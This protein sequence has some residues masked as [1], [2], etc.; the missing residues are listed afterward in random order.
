MRRNAVVAG[1]YPIF[2][3]VS[4]LVF[5]ANALYSLLQGY[6]LLGSLQA[7]TAAM[8]AVATVVSGHA[9]PEPDREA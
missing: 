9:R 3:L 1:R 8:A 5:L 6:W 4:C 2:W 7:V